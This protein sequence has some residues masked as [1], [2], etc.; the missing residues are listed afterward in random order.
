MEAGADAASASDMPPEAG[1]AVW[2]QYMQFAMRNGADPA[3]GQMD[4]RR[5][6]VK[7]RKWAG[8][9][10][11]VFACHA[12]MEWQ[13]L[14]MQPNAHAQNMLIVKRIFELGLRRDNFRSV[15]GY[16]VAFSDWLMSAPPT[17]L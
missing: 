11:H 16:I 10:W 5:V 14:R 7:A 3:A 17:L 9:T 8:C 12:L 1:S 15:P 2:M 4:A 13:Q 6:F